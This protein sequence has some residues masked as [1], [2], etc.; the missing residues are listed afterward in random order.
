M[1]KVTAGRDC[2]GELAPQ[3]AAI[4]D[5]VLFG[6]VWANERA[7]T[8][9][10][11]S[12]ITIAA[13][14]G[15]G[16]LDQS[17]TGHLKTARANGVTREELVDAVTQLAFYAGWP[18]AWAVFA[19]MGEAYGN[20]DPLP[21][22]ALFG[23]GEKIDDTEHFTGDVYVKE[24]SGFEKPMLVDSVTF[25]PG[26]INSWHIHQAGQ[27]LFVTNGRGWYQEEGKPARELR[28]GDIVDIPAGVKHWH[29]A[30]KDSS[31]TH[32]ALEDWSKGAPKWFERVEVAA[33]DMLP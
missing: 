6:Q 30:A 3:F 1:E 8:P 12:L 21:M 19:R 10:D 7:L 14:M 2:L 24:I 29:G 28:P 4:N 31:F 32:L 26:C 23:I 9:R 25:V 20:A 16:V 13:L 11:R 17:L 27:M 15:A 5:D 22:P 18:K 33:Y